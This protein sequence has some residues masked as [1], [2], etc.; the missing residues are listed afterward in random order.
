M[1]TKP[2]ITK[3]RSSGCL[4]L[5]AI[6]MALLSVFADNA[7]ARSHDEVADLKQSM[8]E[9]KKQLEAMQ[10]RLSEIDD[11][12]SQNSAAVEATADAVQEYAD[13]PS[14]FD[15][16]SI[17]GYGELHYNNY[18][19]E[20]GEDK[21]E[22][23][24]HRFVLFFGYDF[25]EQLKFFSE[26]ELEHALAGEGKG[27]EVELEQAFVE[28]SFDDYN[29]ARVG[30][31]L[32]PVGIMNETHEPPTF[33]GVERNTI[34]NVII[35]ATWWAGGVGYTHRWDNGLSFDISLHEGLKADPAD[36]T[37]RIRGGRQK[38]AEADADDLATTARLK[39]TGAPGLELAASLQ[40]QSDITQESGDG[41]DDAYLTELHAIYHRGPFGLRALYARWDMDTEDVP[42][43]TADADGNA[44]ANP[45]L[46]IETNGY[47]EQ[48]GWYVEPSFRMS[49][50]FGVFARYEDVEGGRSRDE[51][52]QWIVGFNY[53][54]HEDVVLKA[55]YLERE[56]DNAADKG[57][58]FDGFNLGFGYQF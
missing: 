24:F 7:I 10:N 5:L 31:F 38:S 51:F 48:E 1:N 2:T 15:R 12:V 26:F 20:S 34:E 16:L 23:D 49:D 27:G 42:A 9:L 25:S 11:T 32:L 8:Q 57:R 6:S 52:D 56:H 44:V 46:G 41:L 17:G 18:D 3:K 55:D 39:Y 28:Y 37:A 54:L 13:K 29:A 33:Y 21:K 50:A 14:A 19:V 43:T 36:G 58:D 40:Y 53:W 22:L 4:S 35:P 47:D 45:A 30:V